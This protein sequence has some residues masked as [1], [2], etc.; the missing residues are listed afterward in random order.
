M[1]TI[2]AAVRRAPGRVILI[3][4][5][6][7]SIGPLVELV[8]SSLKTPS[9]LSTNPLGWPHDPQWSNYRDAW[10]QANL[11]SGMVNS[12]IIVGGTVA[13]VLVIAGLAGYALARLPIPG[14]SVSVVYLLVSSALPI[15]VFLVPL[16]YLWSHLRLYDSLFGLIVIYWGVFSPFATLLVRA[17]IIQAPSEYEDAARVDGAGELAVL[18]RVVLPLAWPGVLT[19]GL[20]VGLWAWNEFLIAVTFVET[21]SRLPASLAFYSFQQGYGRDYTLISAAG[22]TL[23]APMLLLFL[24]LQRRFIAG[25]SSSGLKG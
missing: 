2:T 1:A 24:V 8:F 25:L 18:S 4:L 10:S 3:L 22:V 13:G 9:E 7:F 20:V 16:F 11:G 17:Y 6:I 5:A 15:Q 19:A 12:L 23:A 14:R 21:P